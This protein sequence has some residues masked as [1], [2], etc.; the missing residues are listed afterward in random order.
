MVVGPL[1]TNA[2]LVRNDAT[3][4]GAVIDPGADGRRIVTRCREIGL[5]PRF[6]VNT[7]GHMDHVSA[8]AALKARYPDAQLCI[9]A[10]DAAALL[11]AGRNLSALTGEP[12]TGPPADLELREGQELALGATVLRVLET[13]GHTPGSISLLAPGE[14]PMQLFCG[15]LI[16]EGDVG[17]TDLP[18]GNSRALADSIAR[19][20]MALPDDTVLWPGHG[21]ATTV[22]RERANSPW[23]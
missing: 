18:G 7:H 3:G 8:N 19:K 23:T 6:I 11:D 9:G 10:R 14:Q 16:F 5:V 22:G 1:A 2:Y 13:P 4:E 12:G 15:D 21:E 17:R 20:V